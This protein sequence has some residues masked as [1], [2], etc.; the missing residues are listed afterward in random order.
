MFTAIKNPP[1][2]LCK[3]KNEA[4][5]DVL[6]RSPSPSSFR[7]HHH[8]RNVIAPLASPTSRHRDHRRHA[9]TIAV[10]TS[11]V[12]TPSP[13]Q[14]PSLSPIQRHQGPPLSY[15]FQSMRRW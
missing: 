6:R 4:L 14:P 1:F 3:S 12:V 11:T 10:V 8:H 9:F 7:Y 2:S 15:G 13:S 5:A